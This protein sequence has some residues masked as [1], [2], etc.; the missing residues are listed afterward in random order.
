M[1]ARLLVLLVGFAA[2][3]AGFIYRTSFPIEGERVFCLFDDAMISMTYARNWVEGFGLNWA[4]DGSPVEGFSCPLW[5]FYMALLHLL[6]VPLRFQSL[7]VQL[8]SLLV[9]AANVAAV[10]QLV[11]RH[12]GYER[13]G[14]AL[15]AALLTAAYYPL[16]LWSLQGM[17][18][19]LQALL[20]T[21]AVLLASDI[22]FAERRREPALFAVLTAAALLRLDMLLPVAAVCAFLLLHGGLAAPR[23]RRWLLG[24]GAVAAAL[25][26]YQVFRW[27]YFQDW[28]PN[29]YYL[30]M[31]GLPAG[32]RILRGWLV[33][34]DFL[35]IAGAPLA[36][37]LLGGAALARRRPAYRL[38]LALVT[39]QLGYSVYVGGDAWEWSNVAANR[40]QV[41]VMPLVFALLGGLL[42]AGLDTARRRA[43]REIRLGPGD[44]LAVVPATLACLLLANGLLGVERADERRRNL[45]LLDPPLHVDLHRDTLRKLRGLQRH[46]APEAR[47]LTVLAGIP[48]YFS[49]F[50]MADTLGYNDRYIARLDHVHRLRV[51]DPTQLFKPGHNKLSYAYSLGRLRPDFVF[52]TFWLGER[53]PELMEWYGYERRFGV[54]VRRDTPYLRLDPA[55]R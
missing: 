33:F 6:P 5:T 42:N 23:L 45:L 20:V 10:F 26:A 47:M 35:R 15:P 48:A 34:Q 9:L 52:Q 24:C 1:S 44:L 13:A 50:R 41:V 21:L 39:L 53:E 40:F 16:N 14:H 30:K 51:L 31:T 38:P 49:D 12:F 28:L 8:T 4:R 25:L 43:L 29:T 55:Q 11:R 19:G 7:L 36:L 17:E 2:W 37:A 32:T 3:G 54:W 22:A 46:F 27:L 18:T